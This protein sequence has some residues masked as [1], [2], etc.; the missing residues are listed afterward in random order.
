MGL[1][2]RGPIQCRWNATVY[3]QYFLLFASAMGLFN[4]SHLWVSHRVLQ[5]MKGPDK[6]FVNFYISTRH[7]YNKQIQNVVTGPSISD[8]SNTWTESI[9]R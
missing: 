5:E 8:S 6:Y 7:L 9:K 4:G 1:F 2:I 3:L